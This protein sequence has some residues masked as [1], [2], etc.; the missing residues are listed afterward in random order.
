MKLESS[1]NA[2]NENSEK[3]IDCDVSLGTRFT[4]GRPENGFYKYILES[5]TIANNNQK[6][7]LPINSI[8]G[9]LVTTR[10]ILK[11]SNESKL[12]C[13]VRMNKEPFYGKVTR[14]YAL[15]EQSVKSRELI[16]L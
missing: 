16:P 1:T 5:P 6:A 15:L 7:L 8:E 13:L 11:L 9:E 4:L 2:E 3:R 14:I 12:L 10:G